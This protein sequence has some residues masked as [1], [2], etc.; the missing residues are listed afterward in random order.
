[1]RISHRTA[2]GTSTYPHEVPQFGLGVFLMSEPGECKNACLAALKAGYTHIDTARA[3]SNEHEVGEAIKESG[4][5]REDIF[6]TT[7][8][9][10]M[11]AIGFNDVLEH[12][13]MSLELLDTDFID[14]YLVH[15]PP[16]DIDHRAPVWKGME[17]CLERGWVK[18]IGV[19]N[20]GAHHLEGMREYA[21]YLPSVNQIEINPWLQR[22][23]LRAAT[24]AIGAKV[25]AYSPL[26]RGHK[27]DDPSLVLVAE[28]LGC[29]PAQVAI[30]FCHDIGCITIPKSSREERIVENLASLDVDISSEMGAIEAME[31]GYISGW[32]PTSEP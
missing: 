25:M 21:T 18:A 30:K 31:C 2:N 20:Y 9:R 26:A 3:Y 28:R 4:L 19:S 7:K 17:H 32:D 16:E 22:P 27:L 29:T 11:H 12:C 8:L 23:E 6:I 13:Q 1:M 5:N 10:R 14:L 15:A 24:E